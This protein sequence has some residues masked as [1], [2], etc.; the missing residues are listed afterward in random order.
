MKFEH[1][2]SIGY[3][4]IFDD[5]DKIKIEDLIEG[6]PTIN[7]LETMSFFLAQLHT[8]E[9]DPAMQI[10]CL[11]IWLSRLP[12][13][14]HQ[15]INE[16]IIKINSN[17]RAQYN[18]LNNVSGLILIET[19]LQN[20][21]TLEVSNSLTAD[22]EL[23]LFKAYLMCSQKWID[24]QASKTKVGKI[25]NEEDLIKVLIPTQIPVQEI[26]EFK[27][28]RLQ[29]L[30]AVYFFKFC[31]K[32]AQFSNY[33]KIFLNEYNL[34]SW[35][36]Y[37]LNLLKLYTRKFERLMTPF[38]VEVPEGYPDALNFLQLLTLNIN[39]FNKSDDFLS[40]RESPIYQINQNSFIILNLNFLVDKLYQGIQFDLARVLV[41]NSATFN[42]N[43]I[44][45]TVDFMGIFGE[46]FSE[47][48]LFCNI[49]DYVF[50]K[51]NYK[52][53]KASEIKTHIRDGEP[54]YYMR[55]KSKVYLFEFKNVYIS[56]AV[57]NSGDYMQIQSEVFKK[58][59]SN[60]EGAAKGVTQ[61]INSIKKLRKGDF[62]KFDNYDF[63]NVIIYPIIVYVDFSFNISGINYILNK[64]FHKQID[65]N[66]IANSRNIKNLVLIDLDSLIK[67]QD[68]FRDKTLK[69]NNCLNEYYDLIKSTR[70][71]YLRI[72]TFNIHLHNKTSKYNYDSPKM[73]HDEVLKMIPFVQN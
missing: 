32:D 19:L 51:T 31:E 15:R 62:N 7:G 22:Q 4:D 23:K 33:L 5:Y 53:F 6:I 17:P 35:Q 2:V 40:L 34:D 30:K 64:E 27:D 21:N 52:K 29:I 37:L 10:D 11:R 9:R 8:K 14:I 68:L 39:S 45:N 3:R 69:I 50:E 49:M 36:K 71:I 44:K 57:K 66:K 67:F 46:Y 12:Q 58:L 56:S 41:K 61:L 70:D 26:L 63:N 24:K 60:Q 59:V 25:S 16:F 48:G 43:K 18:F 47:T 13:D 38:R 1:L 73:L 72:T 65:A 42:G 54:D 28:F 20:K 55:D